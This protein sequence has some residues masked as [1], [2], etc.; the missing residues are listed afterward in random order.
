MSDRGDFYS[1]FTKPT[2]WQGLTP[3]EMTLQPSS[4]MT[5]KLGGVSGKTSPKRAPAPVSPD[6]E[7]IIAQSFNLSPEIMQEWERTFRPAHP[8][9]EPEITDESFVPPP[10]PQGGIYKFI[11][12]KGQQAYDMVSPA[13]TNLIKHF[14]GFRDTAYLPTKNDVPTIGYGITKNVKLGDKVTKEQADKMLEDHL[15]EYQ[16]TVKTMVKVPLTDNQLNAVTSLV[17]NIGPTAFRKSRALAA[18]NAG[19][20]TTF[21]KEAFDP[22][23]G[24]VHQKGE[25]LTGLVNR[26]QKEKELFNT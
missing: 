9:P 13:L 1:K 12:Q 15:T 19:D 24:F 3:E 5:S 14:E 21:Q 4:G 26:R 16:D 7:D 10:K 25:K 22:E 6:N 23:H 11:K 2:K 18:L 20:F 8:L 17:Y